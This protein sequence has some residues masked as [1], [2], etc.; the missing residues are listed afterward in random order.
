M[1]SSF[2]NR[3]AFTLIE[4]LVVIAIIAILASILF[5]VFGRARENARRSSC[6]SNLKQ[7]G[8]GLLQYVQDYDEQM[9]RVSYGPSFGDGSSS[10]TSYKWMDASQP[11]IKS[12]Q[13][14]NCPS[15]GSTN[16]VP[17]A[18]SVPNVGPGAGNGN[19]FGSYTMNCA[20]NNRNGPSW[21]EGD[22]AQ[23]VLAEPATT[24]WVGDS[25]AHN[26]GNYPY[27]FL[28]NT[29]KTVPG[30]PSPLRL[31]TGIGSSAALA[32][33]HLDTTNILFCDGHVKA[34]KFDAIAKENPTP[35]T[36][37]NKYPMLSPEAD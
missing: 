3:S 14:F 16:T 34:M 4:L 37:A 24:L 28:G 1:K 19:K 22:V 36:A 18:Y 8:L 2:N 21:N 29:L 26:T 33:R 5:P 20:G 25:E 17:Y 10:A 31:Q 32:A 7:I 35:T 27:R 6:Q 9:V 11:Y 13:V 15:D 30:S 23:A 12:T